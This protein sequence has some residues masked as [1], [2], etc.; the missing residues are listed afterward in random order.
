MKYSQYHEIMEAQ[1]NYCKT[2]SEKKNQEYTPNASSKVDE[3]DIFS[4]FKK[5]AILTGSTPKQALLGMLAKH[6][7]SLVDMCNSNEKFSMDRWTEKIT[8]TM[9][10]LALLK[11]LVAE[12]DENV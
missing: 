7:I 6:L 2:L 11:G 10:Y 5:A 4:Q 9:N 1:F 3:G 8:D 12:E